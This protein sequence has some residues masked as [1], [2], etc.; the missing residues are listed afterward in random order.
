[1]AEWRFGRGWSDAEIKTRLETAEG[2][3]RNFDA[4]LDEMTVHNGWNEYFSE[5]IVGTEPPGA[6][7]SDGPFSRGRSAI[8]T[9]EFSDPR[10]VIGHF[11]PRR[12]LLGRPMLL[13]VRA[14]RLLRYLSGVVVGAVRDEVNDDASVFGFRYETLEGHIERGVEWFLLTKD[15]ATGEIRFRIQAA[16]LPG[17]FPNWWSRVG[18]TVVGPFYQRRWHEK[19]HAL[20]ARLMRQPVH[21]SSVVGDGELFHTDPEVIFQRTKRTA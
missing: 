10:V 17:D 13:E 2:L 19:A 1:M 9:Y 14:M 11:D 15:H 3:E 6:P 16:W 20:L 21:A 7:R 18:F 8:A 12:P 5:A 4:A